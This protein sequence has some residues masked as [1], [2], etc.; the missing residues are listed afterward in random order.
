M[1]RKRKWGK[2]NFQGVGSGGSV[3]AKTRRRVCSVL[4]ELLFFRFHTE[5]GGPSELRSRDIM[6]VV[7]GFIYSVPRCPFFHP[8]PGNAIKPHD[9]SYTRFEH[10]MLENTRIPLVIV[11]DLLNT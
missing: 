7:E 10:L 8:I 3:F 9:D 2:E 5:L 4:I 6:N 11:H 1:S